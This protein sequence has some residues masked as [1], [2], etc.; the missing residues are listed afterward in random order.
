MTVQTWLSL[1]EL[2]VL[3]TGRV[4]KLDDT[5]NNNN[6][7]ILRNALSRFLSLSLSPIRKNK[8]KMTIRVKV[9][10]GNCSFCVILSCWLATQTILPNYPN[11]SFNLVLSVIVSMSHEIIFT[12]LHLHTPNC[13]RLNSPEVTP[14]VVL[15]VTQLS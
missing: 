1:M 2:S 14:A 3:M 7:I 6:D 10:L 8:D 9:S 13:D 12:F 5:G 11:F 4:H 15:E